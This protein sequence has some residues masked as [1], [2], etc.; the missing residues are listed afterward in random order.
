MRGLQDKD[1]WLTLLPELHPNQDAVEMD[2]NDLH[3]SQD[4]TQSKEVAENS[5]VTPWPV[6]LILREQALSDSS[7][8]P[9]Q[10]LSKLCLHA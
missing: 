8:R 3:L 10:L 5:E 6:S 2:L 7:E 9:R 1:D 4:I